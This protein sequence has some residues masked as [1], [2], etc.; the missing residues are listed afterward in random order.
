MMQVVNVCD[1]SY[2]ANTLSL[3]VLDWET[4][5]GLLSGNTL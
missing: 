4:L 5:G 1:W 3:M 2:M